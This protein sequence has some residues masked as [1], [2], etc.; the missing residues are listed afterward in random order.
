M[1]PHPGP[2]LQDDQRGSLGAVRGLRVL[3][4]RNAIVELRASAA[5]AGERALGLVAASGDEVSG[6]GD[7]VLGHVRFTPSLL[8]AARRLVEVA[9]RSPLAVAPARQRQ[10]IASRLVRRGLDQLA[11]RSW[12]VVVL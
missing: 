2:R 7:E 12:P 11:D 9:V 4:R 10:G 8:D 3:A 5:R 6:P 1:L